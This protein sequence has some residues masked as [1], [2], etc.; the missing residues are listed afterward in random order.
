M[1][2]M[3]GG[4]LPI[5]IAGWLL[6]SAAGFG[7]KRAS[8]IQAAG[9]FLVVA[10]I[11]IQPE[12]AS[13]AVR[14]SLL[15]ESLRKN[16]IIDSQ[17]DALSGDTKILTIMFEQFDLVLDGAE[18]STNIARNI[19][20][21]VRAFNPETDVNLSG[22]EAS[23]EVNRAHAEEQ[24][25]VINQRNDTIGESLEILQ[26]QKDRLEAILP[27]EKSALEVMTWFSWVIAIFGT[28]QSSYG[29]A[30]LRN[31]SNVTRLRR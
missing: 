4:I 6:F 16:G 24:K 21:I 25:V 3:W 5:L 26:N 27:S 23:I 8:S 7:Q 19:V 13:Q 15:E 1:V 11:A 9:G 31:R 12:I 28:L 29:G 18:Y 2:G 10:S 14:V 20:S 30:V 17:M 22:R